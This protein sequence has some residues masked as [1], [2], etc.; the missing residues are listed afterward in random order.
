MICAFLVSLELE[1]GYEKTS[2]S[3]LLFVGIREFHRELVNESRGS[4]VTF[5]DHFEMQKHRA[6][7]FELQSTSFFN[8]DDRSTY[9]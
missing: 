8:L 9:L 4:L 2:L 1:V 6:A 3:T 7:M 5:V